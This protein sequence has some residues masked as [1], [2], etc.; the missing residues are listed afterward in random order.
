M[1]H[2]GRLR[3]AGRKFSGPRRPW[4]HNQKVAKQMFIS[5]HTVAFHLRQ[6]SQQN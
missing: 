6:F 3:L 1:N 4:V 2:K 5:V